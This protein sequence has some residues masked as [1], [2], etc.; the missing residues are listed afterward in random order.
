MWYWVGVAIG[1]AFEGLVLIA[2][3]WGTLWALGR[4]LHIVLQSAGLV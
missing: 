4:M 1:V 2:V 3:G